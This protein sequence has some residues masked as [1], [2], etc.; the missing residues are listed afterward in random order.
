MQFPVL[1]FLD[2]N[3]KGALFRVILRLAGR[4]DAQAATMVGTTLCQGAIEFYEVT[5]YAES[6]LVRL[7][8]RS[9]E[10]GVTVE[11]LN[12]AFRGNL[13]AEPAGY[14]IPFRGR[15]GVNLLIDETFNRTYTR[16][17]PPGSNLHPGST[18][19]NDR[20]PTFIAIVLGTW[21]GNISSA[22]EAEEDLNFQGRASNPNP[23]NY[24]LE[25]GDIVFSVIGSILLAGVL[26][27]VILG[28]CVHPFFL[29]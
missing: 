4:T 13:A 18:L 22:Y 8:F 23:I 19:P 15:I 20:D 2:I 10:P 9:L 12:T 26:G 11:S 6:V 7:Y 27:L 17:L 3:R 21:V 29:S 14:T 25:A 16:G 28:F 1:S 5:T 24:G